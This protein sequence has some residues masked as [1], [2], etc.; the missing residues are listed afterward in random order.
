MRDLAS[1]RAQGIDIQAAPDQ[2][3]RAAPNILKQKIIEA[4]IVESCALESWLARQGDPRRFRKSLPKP[5]DQRLRKIKCLNNK[6]KEAYDIPT[7]TGEVSE[8][9]SVRSRKVDRVPDGPLAPARAKAGEEQGDG[10][11]R[12]GGSPGGYLWRRPGGSP[13]SSRPGIGH[14]QADLESGRVRG[15]PVPKLF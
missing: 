10:S 6:V 4:L 8:A 3:W 2:Q 5:A 11:L 14:S 7:V 13:T 12:A 1:S 9:A 15:R